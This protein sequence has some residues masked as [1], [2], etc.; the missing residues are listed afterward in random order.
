M[1]IVQNW[2][3]VVDLFKSI[4]FGYKYVHIYVYVVMES[5]VALIA[6][7]IILFIHCPTN[8][9]LPSILIVVSD[10]W[11]SVSSEFGLS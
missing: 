8:M 5:E 1:A 4:I 7:L 6:K 9:T 3:W 2:I 11:L 10:C